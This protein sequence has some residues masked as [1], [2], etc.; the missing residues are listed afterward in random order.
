MND[1]NALLFFARTDETALLHLKEICR[2]E[3]QRNVY[4]EYFIKKG[5]EHN[6]DLA[7]TGLYMAAARFK[8][9]FK[10]K[11]TLFNYISITIFG[12]IAQEHYPKKGKRTKIFSTL[13]A[14]EIADQGIEAYGRGNN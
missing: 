1:L 7:F 14:K 2:P 8:Y 5:T 12:E 11:R 3:I 4:H 9:L 13:G 10:T 6:R